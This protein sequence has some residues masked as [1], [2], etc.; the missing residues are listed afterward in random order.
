MSTASLVFASVKFY[1]ALVNEIIFKLQLGHTRL[2]F[3]F[4]TCLHSAFCA[5]WVLYYPNLDKYCGAIRMQSTGHPL[6]HYCSGLWER[7]FR[8]SKLIPLVTLYYILRHWI[9]PWE[10]VIHIEIAC[11]TCHLSRKTEQM[12]RFFTLSFMWNTRHSLHISCQWHQ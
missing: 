7:L 11:P 6:V 1:F 8:G 12:H 5:A 10:Y 9:V 2:S 3:F 4:V